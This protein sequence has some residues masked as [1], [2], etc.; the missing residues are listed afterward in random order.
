MKKIIIIIFFLLM[1]ASVRAESIHGI[2]VDGNGAA[3]N[4]A[5]VEASQAKNRQ[6]AMSG[7]DG[8]FTISVKNSE[9]QPWTLRVTAEG[10][11][12]TELTVTPPVTEPVT[13]R[14]GVSGVRHEMA[15]TARRSEAA[16]N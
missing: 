2:V 6:V 9:P 7:G 13:V 11:A 15:V 5:R 10:F 16:V 4:G 12:T 8:S 14:M 3:V 1:H